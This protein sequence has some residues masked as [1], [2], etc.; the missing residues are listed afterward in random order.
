LEFVIE[1]AYNYISQFTLSLLFSGYRESS[2]GR[3]HTG[4]QVTKSLSKCWPS[5]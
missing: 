5:T 3:G 1:I 2:L 4:T